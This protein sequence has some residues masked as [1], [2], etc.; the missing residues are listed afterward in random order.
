MVFDPEEDPSR[1]KAATS[2]HFTARLIEAYLARTRIPSG[3]EEDDVVSPEDDFVA[4]ELE[5]ILVAFGRKMPKQFLVAIDELF[6]QKKYRAQALGLLSSFVR[7]QPPHLHLVLETDLI[8]HL[9][10]CLLIDTSTTIVDLA[11]TILIMFLPHITSSLIPNL[12]KLFLIYSRLLCWDKY[13]ND[14]TDANEGRGSG[15]MSQY[16]ALMQEKFD[17]LLDDPTWEKLHHS[18]DHPEAPPPRVD[19]YFTFLY[20]LFPLNFMSY[21]RKPRKTLKGMAYPDADSLDLNQDLIRDRTEPHRRIHLLHPNFFST[22]AEDEL[23]DN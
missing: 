23:G 20:G 4:H 5:N 1:E 15:I 21:V 13:R 14:T 11:L 10:C 22:T 16:L 8:N 3:G 2:I 7:F 19:Y 18:F 9:Q 12:P 17:P 6:V